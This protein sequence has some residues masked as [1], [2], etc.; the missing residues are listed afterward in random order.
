M[1]RPESHRVAPSDA[2]R[3]G[4]LARLLEEW[5]A[6]GLIRADQV[7]PIV[8]HEQAKTA[9][10]SRIPIAAEAVGYVGAALVISAISLLIGRRW[11]AMPVGLRIATLAIP[12][13]GC[14]AAGR[15]LGSKA[16]AAFMRLAGVLWALSSVALAGA[17]AVVFV[18]AI[19][20]GDPPAHGGLFFVSGIVVI[21]AAVEYGMRRSVLQQLVL[22]AWTLATVLGVVDLL[23]AVIG[24][25]LSTIAWG[26]AVWATAAVWA[27]LGIA[28]R[29]EP[30]AIAR[31][32]GP[33]AMLIGSQV[34]RVDAEALGLWLGLASAALLIG[35][36]VGQSDVVVLLV[37]AV[38]LFQWAP[39]LAVFYLADT[40][41]AEATLLIVG[42][43]LLVAAYVF[44]RLYQ[45]MRTGSE[46]I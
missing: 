3:D 5:C 7:Q 22:F 30:S 14:A 39:Q 1:K 45:R 28:R 10:A 18:D 46:G 11:D 35:I 21:C 25:E 26:S 4:S 42:V 41:G 15:W 20:G 43:V 27:A 24:R 37:G 44:T 2:T 13:A 9:S 8:R 32:V 33:V 40:L 6:A 23:E 17:L 34:V 19:F 16:E 12:A 29:I 36:G 31:L 38:G